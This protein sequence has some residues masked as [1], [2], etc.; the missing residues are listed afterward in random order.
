[1]NRDAF[2]SVDRITW[3][4][5]TSAAC[6][7]FAPVIALV[8]NALLSK[9]ET[10]AWVP[11]SLAVRWSFQVSYGCKRRLEFWLQRRWVFCARRLGC[12]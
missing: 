12:R 9:W 10:D 3:N 6:S 1:M 11:G 5:G 2:G 8:N 4:G 7:P